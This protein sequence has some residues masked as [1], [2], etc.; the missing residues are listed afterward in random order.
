MTVSLLV[1]CKFS[2]AVVTSKVDKNDL[3]PTLVYACSRYRSLCH[4]AYNNI[5]QMCQIHF[6]SQDVLNP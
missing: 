5:T 3:W 6:S 4:G 1:Q 2:P